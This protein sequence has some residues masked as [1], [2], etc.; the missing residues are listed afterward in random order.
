MASANI[1]C[2]ETTSNSVMHDRNFHIVGRAEN[3][4]YGLFPC[5]QNET[6]AFDQARSERVMLQISDGLGARADR[7]ALRH[8]A[9]AETGDLRKDEPHPVCP[10]SSVRQF[11]D[12]LPVDRGLRVDKAPEVERIVHGT[13][14]STV[15]GT[16]LSAVP[17][18]P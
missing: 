5:R 1:S 4:G 6:R 17:D 11:L 3:I 8:R 14:P 2:C 10:F 16:G 18:S 13:T 9:E 15:V 7:K 12:D